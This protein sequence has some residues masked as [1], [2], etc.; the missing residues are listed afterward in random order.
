M[1]ESEPSDVD[2]SIAKQI[3]P[4]SVGRLWRP[5]LALLGVRR[6]D[7]YARLDED[8][9]EI[10]I[11]RYFSTCIPV[12]TVT[13]A[14]AGEGNR[15]CHFGVCVRQADRVALVADSRGAV[16][17]TLAEPQ[18]GTLLGRR[19]TFSTLAISLEQPEDFLEEVHRRL[20][21]LNTEMDA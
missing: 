9:V 6:E 14:R 7:A 21:G 13:L 5:S 1:D 16:E 12:S 8:A 11:G 19:V 4:L 3:Y 2:D 15:I 17:V 18:E 20:H 10:R